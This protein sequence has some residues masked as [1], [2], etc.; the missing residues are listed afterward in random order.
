VIR[1]VLVDDQELVRAGLERILGS[2]DDVSIVAQCADGARALDVIG[3]RH[4]DVVVMDIRMP[5][6]NGIEATRR[7]RGTEGPPVLILTTFDDDETL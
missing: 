2:E 6:M 5:V 1:V 7:I 4:C 3:D